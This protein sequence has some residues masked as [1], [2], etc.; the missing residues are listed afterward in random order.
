MNKYLVMSAAAIVAASAAASTDAMAKGKSGTAHLRILTSGGYY[1]FC[2][3]IHLSWNG[4]SA[5]QTDD[6]STYC[7]YSGH[8]I[9]DG[10]VSKVKGEGKVAAVSVGQAANYAQAWHWDYSMPIASRGTEYFWYTTD[11]VTDLFFEAQPYESVGGAHKPLRTKKMT[12][13]KHFA[14]K[15]R[16]S[17][18]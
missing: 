17:H 13:A 15:I 11:G 6:F 7:G 1:A 4:A 12:V 2:D 5:A 3:D 18:S 16:K 14:E 10:H 8:Y 9:G